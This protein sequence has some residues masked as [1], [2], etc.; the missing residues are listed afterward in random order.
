[1]TRGRRATDG[2]VRQ[3]CKW[4]LR[5]VL[6]TG[7]FLLWAAPA[8]ARDLGAPPTTFP[9]PS[10]PAA[11]IL[12][13]APLVP[14]AGDDVR[15]NALPE[16]ALAEVIID[17]NPT[18]PANLVICGYSRSL[19]TMSTFHSFDAGNTW[20]HVAV[21]DA[22]DG[23]G[24]DVDRF[25]PTLVFDADGRVYVGYGARVLVPEG[26]SDHIVVCRSD[27]GGVT[28]NPGVFVWIAPDVLGT[29]G[30][31]KF[32]L[33]AGPERFNREQQ[34]IMMAWTWNVPPAFGRVD[35][36]IAVSR[37]VDAGATF[38]TPVVINDDSISDRGY[39]LFADPAIGP[40]GVMYVAWND[41]NVNEIRVDHSFDNGNTWGVDVVV[42]TAT[43][44]FRTRV[45]PQPNRGIFAG[46]V[47]DADCSGGVHDGRVYLVY[48]HGSDEDTD[49]L[50]RYSDDNANTF[51]PPVRANDDAPG[52]F[53]FLPWLDVNQSNGRVNVVFYDTREDSINHLARV[54]LA[55]SDT[56]C[57]S[58]LINAPVADVPSN[59]GTSNPRRYPGNYLEYIGVTG[60]GE[61]A[62]VAWTDT[63]NSPEP[64]T[65]YYFDR[66]P[67]D[68]TP[69]A[70]TVTLDPDELWPPNHKWVEVN[71]T[72]T[73]SDEQDPAP[74]FV[75]E[76]ITSNEPGGAEDVKD[77]AW[78]TPDVAF[79]LRAERNG[80]GRGREYA[81]V[82]AASD[83]TGNVARDT[84]YVVVPHDRGGQ[85]QD[86]VAVSRRVTRIRAI[87][88]NPANPSAAVHFETAV[89]G[90][91]RV[92][93]FDVRGRHVAVLA[94]APYPAGA[95]VVRWNGVGVN[96]APAASGVY[97]VLMEAGTI[98]ATRRLVLLR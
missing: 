75:L 20:A 86:S 4:A 56:G 91:V 7:A 36:Q 35:Q 9:P 32:H 24:A 25:D 64:L 16:Q 72:V 33:A 94:D 77:A 90:H 14:F 18:N 76:S 52:S 98:R 23:L 45:P 39:S 5:L 57:E 85:P 88:P 19:K 3:R 79:K 96:G 89:A 70:I 37:S 44:P 13:A 27:D 30:N 12:R 67:P 54:N 55:A 42:E 11:E 53:Q 43:L 84:A 46:P 68:P 61:D 81:V 93:I 49:V 31:D 50:V 97:F 83:A 66:V 65:D 62:F 21:G 87:E 95:H 78:G 48:C 34:V 60:W 73:L 40:N 29:A 74:A 71:A 10:P 28:F 41:I 51:S 47:L 59:N 82:Y 17:V 1:M 6:T 2:G 92:S 38:S 26:T 69:P 58:F 15:V 63:R 22:H 80:K 8:P